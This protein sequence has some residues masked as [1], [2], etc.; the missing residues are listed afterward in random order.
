[1]AIDLL[2]ARIILSLADNNMN[3]ADVAKDLSLHRNTVHYHIRRIKKTTGKDPRHFYELAELIPM[4]EKI[5][6]EWRDI[7]A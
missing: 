3:A 2:Q 7:N 4:A 6:E 5:I 1:M